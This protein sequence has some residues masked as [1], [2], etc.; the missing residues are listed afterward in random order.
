MERPAG[1]HSLNTL[2]HISS[3]T[4][5]DGISRVLLRK[6][7]GLGLGLATSAARL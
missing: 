2:P 4:P 7:H 1:R 6:G 3:T 5:A